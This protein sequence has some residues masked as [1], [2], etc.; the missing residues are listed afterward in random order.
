MVTCSEKHHRETDA[1]P[2]LTDTV[3]GSKRQCGGE[4]L[5]TTRSREFVKL[6]A[7]VKP[8]EIHRVGT[9]TKRGS[10]YYSAARMTLLDYVSSETLEGRTPDTPADN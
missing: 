10:D 3:L 7:V 5:V 4:E 1:D 2:E 9:L 6:T 8:R